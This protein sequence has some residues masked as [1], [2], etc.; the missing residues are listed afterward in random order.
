VRRLAPKR[1]RLLSELPAF[2]VTADE[3]PSTE[4]RAKHAVLGFQVIDHRRLLPL[5]KT[6]NQHEQDLQQ[7]HRSNHEAVDTGCF[8]LRRQPLR[9]SRR[10][11]TAWSNL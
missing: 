8:A 9:S 2:G 3:P 5:Q 7:S 4:A 6:R 1:P 10:H 11:P